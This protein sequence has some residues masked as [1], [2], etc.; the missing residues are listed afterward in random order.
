M[1]FLV[2]FTYDTTAD[3]GTVTATV[4]N[5]GHRWLTALGP[6]SGDTAVLDIESATGGIFDNPTP[7]TSTAAGSYG[8]ITLKFTD[9]SSG[10]ITYTLIDSGL[11]DVI[12]ISR[13]APDNV[14]LCMDLADDGM[15]STSSQPLSE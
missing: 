10:S 12:P 3:D 9:C 14:A 11:S 8:S 15:L 2:W 5:P 4:G 1:V 13:L 7:I 6:Y